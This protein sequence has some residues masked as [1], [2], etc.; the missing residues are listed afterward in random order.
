MIGK[1]PP[2]QNTNYICS[3]V[4]RIESVFC[5]N[6]DNKDCIIYYPQVFLGEC[7]YTPMINRR[8]LL[9][10]TDL[11]NNEPETESESEEEFNENIAQ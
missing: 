7:R 9:D 6:K 2:R 1:I 4:I 11:L 10:E 8:L 5:N 3:I